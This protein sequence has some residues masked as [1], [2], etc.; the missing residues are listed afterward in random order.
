M[1][2]GGASAPGPPRLMM[3][4]ETRQ[5]PRELRMRL[6]ELADDLRRLEAKIREGGGPDKIE[7]QHQQ[8]KL[9]ARE[10]IDLLFDK[11]SF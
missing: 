6:R 8:G 3:K 1:E 7:R 11:E 5:A 2:T 10:R 9:T 4:S